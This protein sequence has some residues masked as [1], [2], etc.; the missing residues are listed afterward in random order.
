MTLPSR[1]RRV[2]KYL[3]V[4]TVSKSLSAAEAIGLQR[5]LCSIFKTEQVTASSANEWKLISPLDPGEVERDFRKLTASYG[6]VEIRAG[7]KLN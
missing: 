4:L 3:Y 2:P 5:E 1:V 6:P 7:A